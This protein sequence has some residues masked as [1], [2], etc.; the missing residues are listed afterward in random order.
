MTNI[1]TSIGIGTLGFHSDATTIEN[2]VLIPLTGVVTTINLAASV[3]I[4]KISAEV[5]N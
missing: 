2:Q 5:T 1:T 3:K 4:I